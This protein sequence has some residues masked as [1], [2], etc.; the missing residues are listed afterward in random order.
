MNIDERLERLVERHEALAQSVELLVAANRENSEL[1][2]ENSELTRENSVHI[3]KLIEVTNQDAENI[4]ALARIAESHDHRL[5][6]L[7]DSPS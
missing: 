2:R 3:G 5:T 4:R 7:E 6:D 1:I